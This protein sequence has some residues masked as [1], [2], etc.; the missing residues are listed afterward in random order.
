MEEKALVEDSNSQNASLTLV[1]ITKQPGQNNKRKLTFSDNS[2]IILLNDIIRDQALCQGQ[3][4][5]VRTKNKLLSQ[6]VRLEIKKKALLFLSRRSHSYWQIKNKLEKK[7]FAKQDVSFILDELRGHGYVDDREFARMWIDSRI[8]HHY[9]GRFI[10]FTG[11]MRTGVARKIAED[12][13]AVYSEQEEY[14]NLLKLL[15]KIK[16]AKD[17]NPKKIMRRLKT[18]GFPLNLILKAL[19][20]NN[21]LI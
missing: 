7:G 20:Q 12:S 3:V 19:K 4:I 6:S 18:R 10:L 5:D 21:F 17:D 16:I 11:L 8:K 2:H 13:V 9:E 14:T 1:S 15:E